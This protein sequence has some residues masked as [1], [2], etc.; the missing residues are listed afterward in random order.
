STH[1]KKACGQLV[2]L[3]YDITAFT[4]AA[5]QRCSLQRPLVIS[6]LAAGFVLR[7][8]QHLSDPHLATRQ[9]SWRNNR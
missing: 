3:G 8:F 2:L 1:S 7:C 4:P 9:C 6:Y 5:Y